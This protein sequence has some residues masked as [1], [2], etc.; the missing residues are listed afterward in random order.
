MADGKTVCSS[1]NAAIRRAVRYEMGECP[2]L[3]PLKTAITRIIRMNQS[4]WPQRH[5]SPR[6]KLKVRSIWPGSTS[7]VKSG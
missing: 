5:H 6:M 2:G 4:A 3:S 7:W 1:R